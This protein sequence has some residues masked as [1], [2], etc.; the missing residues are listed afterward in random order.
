MFTG[1]TLT[2]QAA[3]DWGIVSWV[4]SHDDLL[5]V[6]RD[7]LAQCARTAPGTRSVIKASLDDYLGLFDRIG[8]Q[9]SLA[10]EEAREGFRAF[11]EKRSPSWVHPDPRVAGCLQGPTPGGRIR[12]PLQRSQVGSR[13]PIWL[14]V[15]MVYFGWK[16]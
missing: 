16:R 15:P 2:A 10:G 4:V 9:T 1:R 11:K 14:R 13:S 12:T 5:P 7:L 3:L 6:A 8:M